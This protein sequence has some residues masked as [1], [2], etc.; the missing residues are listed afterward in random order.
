MARYDPIPPEAERWGKALLDAAYEVHTVLGPGFLE[1]IYEDALCYE[2]ALRQVPF[3]RQKA[4][5]VPYKGYWI[6]GQ[7]LDLLVGGLVVA[8]SKAV[9]EI[10]PVHQAQLMSYLKAT[11]LRLG[12]LINFSVLHLRDGIH[13]GFKN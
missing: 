3:E 2:L 5:A 7:R 13:C 11:G 12:F 8:E 1:R 6:E 9:D 10:H 4:I